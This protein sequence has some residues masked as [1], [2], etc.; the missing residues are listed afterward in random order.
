MP[1]YA[2]AAERMST[3][4]ASL[5]KYLNACMHDVWIDECDIVCDACICMHVIM[6]VRM[7]VCMYV[8]MM[9]A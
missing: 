5:H 6:H 3:E 9:N 8:S 4:A 1:S 2:S 7:Y